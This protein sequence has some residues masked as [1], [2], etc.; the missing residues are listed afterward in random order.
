MFAHMYTFWTAG[1]IPTSFYQEQ[2]LD[3]NT[4]TFYSIN[5]SDALNNS[6]KQQNNSRKEACGLRYEYENLMFV[7][8][9]IDTFLSLILPVISIVA[10]NTMLARNLFLFRQRFI[11]EEMFHE[12]SVVTSSAV[13]PNT[14]GE[15]HHEMPANTQVGIIIVKKNRFNKL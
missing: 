9:I 13:L 14:S 1:I 2:T 4:T 12:E 8:N 6:R 11:R 3:T 10:M 5:N 15:K 7:I